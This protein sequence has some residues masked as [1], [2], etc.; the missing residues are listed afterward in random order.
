[1]RRLF[2]MVLSVTLAVAGLAG[3]GHSLEIGQMVNLTALGV[4]PAPVAAAATPAI[5]S[6]QPPLPDYAANSTSAVFG[7]NLFTGAFARPGV[8]QFNSDY[9]VAVGDQIQVRLWG[10]FEFDALLVVDPQGNVFVPKIGPLK[11]LG[12]RNQDLQRVAEIAVKKVFVANVYS[13]ASLAAAQPVCVFVSGFVNRPGL[14]CGTS[15]DSL[16]HYLDLAG[17]IDPA[18]GS[19]LNVQV[20]RGDETRA[21]VNLYDFLLEGRIPLIQLTGGDVIFVS[22]RQNTVTVGGLAENAKHFEFS[23]SARTVADLVRIAKPFARATHVRVRRNTGTIR[24]TEYYQLEDSSKVVLQNGDEIEFTADKK[25]GTITV[26]VEGEHRSAQEYV[27][28]NGSRF[29]ELIKQVE[30]SERSDSA[31]IQLYRESVRERQK[32]MFATAL[33]SL[34]TSVLTARSNTSDEAILRKEEA[35]LILQWIERAKRVEP[36]GQVAISAADGR[37]DL[38]L[39]NGDVIRVPIKDGLVLINGE[40]LFPTTVLYEEK[41]STDEYIRRAGGFTQSADTSRVIVAHLD[42]SFDEVK[43]RGFFNNRSTAVPVRAGDEILV[44][45]RIDVKSMQIFKDLTQILFQIAVSAKVIVG[46]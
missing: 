22:Q 3:N 35:S 4:P 31:N 41:R 34:E 21:T 37:D 27:L 38:L 25:T 7:A 30:F 20:K 11:V 13:Y 16:L 19:F 26:R 24:N 46:L 5:V 28:P 36:S 29:G 12:L 18:R 9:L 6:P 17:G 23:D 39:E 33:R 42:G 45:P 40:V 44:L 15:M 10:A 14:Y 2:V 32:Q 8:T 43:P 1:M